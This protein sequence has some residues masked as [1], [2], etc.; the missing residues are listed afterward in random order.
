MRYKP[1]L[2]SLFSTMACHSA[3]RAN[4]FLSIHEMN[5]LLRQ[6]EQTPNGGQCNHGRPTW[7]QLSHQQMDAWFKRGQ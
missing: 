6:I 7:V 3:I 2:N 4:R 1:R 5:D